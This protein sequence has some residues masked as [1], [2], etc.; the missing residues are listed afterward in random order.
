MNGPREPLAT[1]SNEAHLT[2]GG[3]NFASK[4]SRQ[5]FK[6]KHPFELIRIPYAVDMKELAHE[7]K[8]AGKY[9]A[10]LLKVNVQSFRCL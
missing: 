10:Y 4:A 6:A 2:N 1:A 7:V 5:E 3:I 9:W 8:F